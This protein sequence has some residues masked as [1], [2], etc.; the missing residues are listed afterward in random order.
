MSSD[1]A[2]VAQHHQLVID[3]DITI[4]CCRKLIQSMDR[5]LSRLNLSEQ[6]LDLNSKVRAVFEDRATRDFQTFIERKNPCID[7]PDNCLQLGCAFYLSECP[8]ILTCLIAKRP[9]SRN[10]CLSNK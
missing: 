2:S 5:T 7:A 9:R 8:E 4:R 1:L 3:L 10:P 6:H